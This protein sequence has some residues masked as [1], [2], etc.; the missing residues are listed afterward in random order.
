MLSIWVKNIL[1]I[2]RF[3]GVFIYPHNKLKYERL[4]NERK[5]VLP[6]YDNQV[7]SVSIIRRFKTYLFRNKK[8]TLIVIDTNKCSLYNRQYNIKGGNYNG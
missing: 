3:L 7:S 8:R 2:V 5:R 6:K 1:V 4:I